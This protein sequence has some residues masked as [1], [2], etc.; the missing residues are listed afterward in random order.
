MGTSPFF[1][2]GY[3]DAADLHG[4]VPYRKTFKIESETLPQSA[5]GI[6]AKIPF[7]VIDDPTVLTARD[8]PTMKDV[9]GRAGF[10]NPFQ[11]RPDS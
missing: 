5:S 8:W 9:Q 4:L 11:G 1:G 3:E 10:L 7:Q 2:S 6:N